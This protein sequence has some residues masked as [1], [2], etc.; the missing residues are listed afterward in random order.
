METKC[1]RCKYLLKSGSCKYVRCKSEIFV[2]ETKKIIDF[3]MSNNIPASIYV[4]MASKSILVIIL[5]KKKVTF[6]T[7]TL[8]EDYNIQ[9][10]RKIKHNLKNW[11]DA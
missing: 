1:A 8:F 9:D 2:A 11:L 5:E 10:I 4:H 7:G 3:T 6:N